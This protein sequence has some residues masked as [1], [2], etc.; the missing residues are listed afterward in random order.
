[1]EYWSIGSENP[2]THYSI[3]PTLH[4][5]I[6]L[7]SSI[8]PVVPRFSRAD[9]GVEQGA[10]GHSADHGA[11][12]AGRRA[13]V[14]D[15]RRRHCAEDDAHA[16]ALFVL[17]A[18]IVRDRDAD[19]SEVHHLARREFYIFAHQGWTGFRDCDFRQDFICVHDRL[20]GPFKKRFQGD[21]ALTAG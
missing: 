2:K 8:T 15:R 19:I 13:H 16:V 12:I 20:A 21:R 6:L 3:I 11:A 10:F 14:A 9:R 4:H 7:I 17:R 5:P 1:M 18:E